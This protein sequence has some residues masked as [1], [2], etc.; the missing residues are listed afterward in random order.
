MTSVKGSP[1]SKIL[2][3]EKDIIEENGIRLEFHFIS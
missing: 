3:K 1:S 2:S